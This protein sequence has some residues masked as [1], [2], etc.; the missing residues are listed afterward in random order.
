MNKKRIIKWLA[1][2]TGLYYVLEFVLPEKVGGE[3][4]QFEV[5]APAAVSQA[6]GSATVWYVGAYS[7]THSA[8]GRI[9]V[10]A[11]GTFA[12]EPEP[13]LRRSVLREYDQRGVQ[14]LAIVPLDGGYRMYYLGRA[15]DNANPLCLATSPDGR[16]WQRHGPMELDVRAAAPADPSATT[17]VTDAA[18]KLLRATA[19]AAAPVAGTVQ[20]FVGGTVLVNDAPVT[21]IMR[22]LPG[23]PAAPGKTAAQMLSLPGLL[24]VAELR[25]L[26]TLPDGD[27]ALLW[28]RQDAAGWHLYRIASD[29]AIADRGSVQLPAD[30]ER[31]LETRT[32][33]VVR[34]VD[35]FD[36]W[37]GLACELKKADTPESSLLKTWLARAHSADGLTW[38]YT[39]DAD[40]APT[41][42]LRPGPRGQPTYLTRASVK[43]GQ[44][45]DILGSFALGLAVLN[46][47]LLHGGTLAKRRRGMSNAALFF[48]SFVVMYIAVFFGKDAAGPTAWKPTYE[49]LFK[50]VQQP[51][52]SAIF[53]MITFYMVSAAYRSFRVR[54]L[55]SG[56]M[57]FAAIVVMLGGVPLGVA[58]TDWLPHRLDWLKIPNVKEVLLAVV[59][60]AAYRGVLFGILIGGLAM[61]L[62]MWLGLE[63]SLFRGVESK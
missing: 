26:A 46:L 50:Y 31:K 6:D 40:G 39:T 2:L 51:M 57:L 45:F 32:L 7:N 13:A 8:V 29:G 44:A 28:T 1:F 38:T 63:E 14:S 15:S 55:E 59:N 37:L 33:A 41:A 27:G 18:P 21:A 10:A 4:D 58:L 36:A 53:A 3:F 43:L 19:V 25:A 62:R 23:A 34:A 42:A 30:L 54:S 12:R 48:V 49:F 5:T 56:L 16:Q 47:V 61:S 11:D 52:S 9:D 24:P 22:A 17:A 60:S 35:G 20:L